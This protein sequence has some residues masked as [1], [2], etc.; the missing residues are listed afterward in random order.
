MSEERHNPSVAVAVS[1]FGERGA[2]AACVRGPLAFRGIPADRRA[3]PAEASTMSLFGP[4]WSRR[5]A[6][7]PWAPAARGL[8]GGEV[9]K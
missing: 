3:R 6:C 5:L 9:A 7:G 2:I 4:A 1:R 8:P